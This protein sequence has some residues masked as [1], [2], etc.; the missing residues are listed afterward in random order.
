MLTGPG[1]LVIAYVPLMAR[2]G[3]AALSILALTIGSGSAAALA[4]STGSR[5][6]IP[7]GPS[8]ARTRAG[9]SRAQVYS[10]GDAAFGCAAGGGRSFRLGVTLSCIGSELVGPVVVAGP[11]AAYGSERCGVDT[12]FTRV[13]VRDLRTGARL[14]ASPAVTAPGAESFVS[15]GSLVARRNGAA[16]WIAVARSLGSHLSHIELRRVNGHGVTLLDSGGAIGPRS[17]RLHGTWLTWRHGGQ[18]RTAKLA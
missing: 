8:G 10:V 7:C 12:G 4:F 17:L 11:I 1:A 15:L 3:A 9:N 13:L 5:P 6:R 14:S 18:P 16:A 2:L